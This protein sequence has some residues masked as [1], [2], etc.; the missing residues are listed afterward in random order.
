[1]FFQLR[2]K[3]EGTNSNS[4]GILYFGNLLLSFSMSP[5]NSKNLVGAFL[6]SIALQSTIESAN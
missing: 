3:R 5:R 4:M 6:D 2:L 1:M